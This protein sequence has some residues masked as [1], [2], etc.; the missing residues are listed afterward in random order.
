[1]ADPPRVVDRPHGARL[2]EPEAEEAVVPDLDLPP[3][4][5]K[6][7][8]SSVKPGARPSGKPT[9]PGGAPSRRPPQVVATS[10]SSM[11]FDDDVV[12]QARIELDAAPISG[13]ALATPAHRREYGRSFAEAEVIVRPKRRSLWARLVFALFFLLVVAGVGAALAAPYYVK[14]WVAERARRS[15]LA[16]T[17]DKVVFRPDALRLTGTQVGVLGLEGVSLRVGEVEIAL[18]KMEPRAIVVHGLDVTLRGDARELGAT[19]AQWAAA[20][21]QPL[22][23]HASSGHVTW[24]NPFG[25]GTQLDTF[26]TTISTASRLD[27]SAPSLMVGTPRGKLGPWTIALSESGSEGRLTLGLD[28]SLPSSKMVLSLQKD[29]GVAVELDVPQSPLARLGVPADAL[30]LSSDPTVEAHLDVARKSAGPIDGHVTFGFYAL[31]FVASH[32]PASPLDVRL[33]AGFSGD[34]ADAIALKDGAVGVGAAKGKV[35]GIL[36]LKD[37]SARADVSMT[38]SGAASS[39]PAALVLDTRDLAPRPPK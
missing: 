5:S 23:I 26:D 2:G 19:L 16:V 39:L 12:P 15:G 38:W 36:S 32:P 22:A 17:V 33:Q 7:S 1:M 27:V 28:P 13:R 4:S 34:S 3:R 11:S 29:G 31:R 21:P 6:P 37:R 30:G 18:E 25:E 14:S 20:L 10:S 35:T 24:V 8:M 9:D